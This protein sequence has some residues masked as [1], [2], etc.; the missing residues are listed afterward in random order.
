M[1][2]ASSAGSEGAK[3]PFLLHLEAYLA[4]RDGVDKLLKIMRYTSK[5][6]ISS[7][8]LVANTNPAVV[9]RLREFEASV[10]TSRKAFRLG[11]F[12]Q[13][14]NALRGSS[15]NFS[16]K[17]GI[18]E[19]IAYGGEGIYYFVEQFIWLAKAG[20]IDKRYSK[21]L[22]KLS[23]WAEFIGY[24]GSVSLKA[25]E[26]LALLDQETKIIDGFRK[27]SEGGEKELPADLAKQLHKLQAK[28]FMKALSLIQD[29]ADSLLSLSDI[30]DERGVLANPSLLAFSGLV[31][32]LI[33]AH[34][35]WLSS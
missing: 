4:R 10:G 29:F 20:L 31:S 19:L 26:I 9:A 35:N 33:S 25:L 7:Q 6:L 1:A 3:R 28:R 5:L 15:S 30:L 11:K 18:L 12:V 22:Q 23:A 16:S 17:E 13:D 21:K 14:L 24:F 8:H 32:A 27:K 2:A 34:K